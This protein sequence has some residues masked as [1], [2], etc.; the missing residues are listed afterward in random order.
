MKVELSETTS[1]RLR[2][3]AEEGGYPGIEAALDALLEMQQSPAYSDE[4][5]RRLAE[6]G[7]SSLTR[8][9]HTP[10][11]VAAEARALVARKALSTKR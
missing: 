1:A 9:S 4:E 3:L 5:L 8:G 6:S 2:I 7:R 10:E 11:S